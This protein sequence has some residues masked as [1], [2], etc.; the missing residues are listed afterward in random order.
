MSKY[1]TQISITDGVTTKK[2]VFTDILVG[3]LSVNEVVNLLK[4]ESK[5]PVWEWFIHFTQ[6]EAISNGLSFNKNGLSGTVTVNDKKIE[7]EP[8][9]HKSELG[10]MSALKLEAVKQYLAREAI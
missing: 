6:C 7:V 1:Y 3:E 10:L 5:K 4:F 9:E 2:K 8:F